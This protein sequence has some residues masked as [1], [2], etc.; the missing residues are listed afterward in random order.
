MLFAR[1]LIH[2]PG[3]FKQVQNKG[4]NGDSTGTG[5]TEQTKIGFVRSVRLPTA[6][7]INMTQ[8]CGIGPLLIVVGGGVV[9]TGSI[10]MRC[11]REAFLARTITP[12]GSLV[13][14]VPALLG[15]ESGL[16]GAAALISSMRR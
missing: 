9:H 3:F 16:W 15:D 8:M 12:V 14:I 5:E 10:L 4:T 6:I 1:D 13:L 2:S 11:A 7:A